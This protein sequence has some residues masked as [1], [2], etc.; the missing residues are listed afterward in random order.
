MR[1]FSIFWKRKKLFLHTLS[2]FSPS[3]P[4][5]PGSPCLPYRISE[6]QIIWP[7]STIINFSFLKKLPCWVCGR[8]KHEN[9]VLSNELIKVKLPLWKI[10]K[11]DVLCVS[12]ASFDH[13]V[14]FIPLQISTP[15]FFIT[16]CLIITVNML[17][18]KIA[19]NEICRE[20]NVAKCNLG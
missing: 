18:V 13:G 5:N 7:S 6:P 14:G 12:P 19:S 20:L 8:E 11:G 9:L 3:L 15:G 10:W 4:L 2:P 17:I 1:Y 16:P